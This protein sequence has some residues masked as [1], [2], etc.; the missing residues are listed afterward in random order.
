MRGML[1]VM[2]GCLISLSAVAAQGGNWFAI[3]Y[4]GA[5]EW[6]V[7]RGLDTKE[8]AVKQATD[9]CKKASKVG[10]C[11]VLDAKS[12]AGYLVLA[13]SPSQ[14]AYAIADD[15]AAARKKALDSCAKSTPKE[16]T[17]EIV[18]SKPNG[19]MR[20][21]N[22]APAAAENC[23]PRTSHIT[24]QSQCSNGNCIV[25]YA[26]GCKMRVQVNAKFNP[27]N[28]QWEFPSPSC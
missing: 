24:C 17:C 27:F 26:N 28:N 22:K 6:G 10:K 3:A 20:V 12:L 1:R 2:V 19:H 23:R 15:E 5:G 16:E 13:T 25:T 21:A 14:I 8:K 18:L 4:D 11:K 9:G 7:S